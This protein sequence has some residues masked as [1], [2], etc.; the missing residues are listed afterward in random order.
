MQFVSPKLYSYCCLFAQPWNKDLSNSIR[1]VSS[2]M[3]KIRQSANKCPVTASQAKHW[4]CQVLKNINV[5]CR[6]CESANLGEKKCMPNAPGDQGS[7]LCLKM[8]TLIFAIL[9]FRV[10][11]R[12]LNSLSYSPL[13][14]HHNSQPVHINTHKYPTYPAKIWEMNCNSL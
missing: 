10:H 6:G 1:L 2:I 11:L 8:H 14:S 12:K 7:Q 9:Y 5:K 13:A 3:W 4:R